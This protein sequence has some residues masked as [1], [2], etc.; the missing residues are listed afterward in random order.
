MKPFFFLGAQ[1][2]VASICPVGGSHST[3]FCDRSKEDGGRNGWGRVEAKA[4]G[5]YL[6]LNEGDSGKKGIFRVGCF[7][8]LC[9]RF[10]S[11]KGE[12]QLPTDI[13]QEFHSRARARC[14]SR[15]TKAPSLAGTSSCEVKVRRKKEM[16]YWRQRDRHAQW[17]FFFFL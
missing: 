8:L 15:M 5:I 9:Y 17:R 6:S 10:R 12:I 7:L 14:F 13:A 16:R 1:K 4:E 3:Q 11:L 2:V